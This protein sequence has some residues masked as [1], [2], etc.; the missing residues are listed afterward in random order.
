M[1]SIFSLYPELLNSEKSDIR[2]GDL[3]K[4]CFAQFDDLKNGSMLVDFWDPEFVE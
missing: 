1:I 2:L 4:I 3:L